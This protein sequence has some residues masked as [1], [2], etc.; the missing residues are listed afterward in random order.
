M[1]DAAEMVGPGH[2]GPSLPPAPMLFVAIAVLACVST[3]VGLAISAAVKSN[4]QTMP[5]LVIIVMVQMVFCGGL[6][7][8]AA[9]GARW[10]SWLFPSY[11][12]Y[13]AAAQAV[14]LPF[15]AEAGKAPQV[16]PAEDRRNDDDAPILY[17][18]WEPTLQNSLLCYGVLVLM[19]VLL[20]LF[21]YSRLRLK[22]H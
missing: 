9:E 14:D 10:I 11:W 18:I 16:L 19:S 20:S 4:E 7:P 1:P 17:A 6:F 8:I 13:A 3:L 22:K 21:V 2:E 15:T 12:G 5:P